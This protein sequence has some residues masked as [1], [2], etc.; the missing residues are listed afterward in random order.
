MYNKNYHMIV[1]CCRCFARIWTVTWGRI[2]AQY[3]SSISVSHS[4]TLLS[5]SLSSLS[6]TLLSS[7]SHCLFSHSTTHTCTHKH[8][9]KRL[10]TKVSTTMI[11]ELDRS[12]QNEPPHDKT[13][14]TTVCPTKTQISLGICP[15][16]SESSL[17]AQWVAKDPSFLH[18]DSEDSDLSLR[19]AHMPFCWLCHVVAEIMSHWMAKPTKWHVRPATTQIS[20]GIHPV[21]S[22]LAV[23]LKEA[24]VFSY[25]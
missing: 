21:W 13:N 24:R 18:A 7:L 22:V 14:K 4:V 19:W 20:L 11:H 1:F 6:V 5:L 16:W 9:I 3:G 10:R 25:P 2:T 17:C 23:R 8:I 15:V 12:K